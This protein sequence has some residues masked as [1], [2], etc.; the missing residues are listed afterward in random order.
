MRTSLCKNE[1]GLLNCRC[2][3]C[4]FIFF[5]FAGVRGDFVFRRSDVMMDGCF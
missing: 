5:F 3:A 1:M 4:P 2:P